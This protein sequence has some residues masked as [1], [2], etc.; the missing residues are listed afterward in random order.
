MA[1]PLGFTVTQIGQ[2]EICVWLI[3]STTIVV[4][5]YLFCH[6]VDNQR[7]LTQGWGPN[8][9]QLLMSSCRNRDEY[10][11]GFAIVLFHCVGIW[12]HFAKFEIQGRGAG[13]HV[14]IYYHWTGRW[15]TVATFVM[16]VVVILRIR[17]GLI[18]SREVGG[19]AIFQLIVPNE[20]WLFPHW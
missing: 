12:M 3:M 8:I 2:R 14:G 19:R 5:I 11:G 1:G 20:Y 4:S 7:Y 15:A 13:G 10:V 17:T 6:C 16:S 18:I 9:V